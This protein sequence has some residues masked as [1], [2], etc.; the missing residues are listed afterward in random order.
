[1]SDAIVLV[2]N[3]R[4][5]LT[6]NR[7]VCEL[8][9]TSAEALVGRPFDPVDLWAPLA[10]LDDELFNARM[11]HAVEHAHQNQQEQFDGRNGS[12]QFRIV[13]VH[14]ASGRPLAQLW[15]VQDVTAEVRSRRLLE[16]QDAQLRALQKM[17]RSL[18]SVTSVDELLTTTTNQLSELM[19]IEAAGVAIRYRDVDRR[20]RQMIDTGGA[21]CP[22]EQGAHIAEAVRAELMPDVLAR[23]DT[24]H[25]AELAQAGPWA[26]PFRDMGMETLASTALQS[27]EKTQGIIWIARRGGETIDRNHIFL[28]E[29]LA[30]MLSTALQNAELRDEMRRLEMTDP[31]TGL[32]SF[33]Q[34]NSIVSRVTR[35][36]EPW[37]MLV[38][39]VD[40]FGR[41]NDEYGL[42]VADDAL[43]HV[44]GVIRGS[45][46]A[47]DY[48][49]RYTEDK[50]IIISPGAPAAAA[51]AWPNASAHA[52]PN[53]PSPPTRASPS[54][55]PARSAWRAGPTTAT[56]PTCSAT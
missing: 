10:M 13:P 16:Q 12:Y 47:S 5:V 52:S 40:G 18:H 19:G 37:A 43:R 11:K 9:N 30:P 6:A 23:S 38:I 35:H 44:A 1:M 27:Q 2:S 42:A 53:A 26:Q 29:A 49:L 22:I 7:R 31:V 20:S 36:A 39:D 41:I 45:S 17:G 50:F 25:W 54:T 32:P 56:T 21:S 51:A 15:V 4:C 55:P 3:D 8:L 48:V 46:R 14:D 24:S 34:Y 33:R 28:L